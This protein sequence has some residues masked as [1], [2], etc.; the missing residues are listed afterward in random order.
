MSDG[1][2]KDYLFGEKIS[3]VDKEYIKLYFC[4]KLNFLKM[5]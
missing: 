1:R 5:K 4:S 3:P 2:Q